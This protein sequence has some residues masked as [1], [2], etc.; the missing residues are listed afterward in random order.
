[1]KNICGIFSLSSLTAWIWIYI[2]RLY[3]L[4][5]VTFI[6]HCLAGYYTCHLN[7]PI[8]QF[9]TSIKVHIIMTQWRVKRIVLNNFRAPW[10]NANIH[11]VKLRL[12]PGFTCQNTQLV[13]SFQFA[14]G[15]AITYTLTQLWLE[16]TT[17]ILLL[18]LLWLCT[19]NTLFFNL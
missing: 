12:G 17:V 16:T 4:H 14:Y 7:L 1:M 13:G 19:N 3:I 15:K 5:N 6:Y 8:N 18:L 2:S 9:T 10:F 11:L